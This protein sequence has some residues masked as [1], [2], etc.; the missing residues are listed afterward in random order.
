[1]PK[2]L[3]RYHDAKL[4]IAGK[5]GMIDELKQEV[6]NLGLGN[7]VCFAGYLSGKDVSKMYKVADISVFPSTYEPFG[8]V[9]L[10]AMLA[11]IP[12][13]VSDIGGLNEIVEHRQTGMKS[14][15]GNS[16]SIADSILELLFDPALCSNM[17]K[18]AKTK[19]RNEYNWNKI[20]Q[21]THFTYQKAI[22]ETVADRQRKQLEQE[23]ANKTKK[24][25]KSEITN[26]L[27][28]RK[29]Q[30]YA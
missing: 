23:K 25:A 5:G 3:E 15:C 16:N 7:K 11:E 18:K 17:V 10:E 12:V 27:T 21:D 6:Q 19:V 1:M 13:V 8:I 30:A 28:F 20:A 4:V 9:T 22:C 14:Y 2:I 29:N 24:T 26:L